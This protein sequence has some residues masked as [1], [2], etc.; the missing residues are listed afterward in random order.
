[1]KNDKKSSGNGN[2]ITSVEGGN[3]IIK[4]K[5]DEEGT[6]SKSGK[7]YIIASTRGARNVEGVTVSLNVY[8]PV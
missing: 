1:M 3:L 6:L 7:S 8:T 5:L 4:V 2:V